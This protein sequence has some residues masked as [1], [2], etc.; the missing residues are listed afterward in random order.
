MTTILRAALAAAMVLAPLPAL[1][2]QQPSP[3]SAGGA[4]QGTPPAFPATP[5][6]E[7]GKAL[8]EALN[9]D[10]ETA[11]R[12]F[13]DTR[14]AERLDVGW[15]RD[16]YAALLA[17]LRQQSGGVEVTRVREMGSGLGVFVRS[18]T[19]GHRL[20]I[21]VGMRGT[22]EVEL[23]GMHPTHPPV[24]AE[25]PAEK[26]DDE[27][28]AAAVGRHLEAVAAADRFSGV[29]V[30]A[31][32]DR[33][34]LRRAYGMADRERGVPMTPE[35]RAATAS[36]G[37][38]A[39]GVAVA[40][41]VEAGKLRFT[42]TLGSLLP[43]HP[44]PDARR[45]TIHQLLTHTAGIAD[46]FASPRFVRGA[47]Y[48]TWRDYLP[49][50]ASE[51]LTM[52]PGERFGYS[53]GNF[54]V[55]AAVVEKASGMPFER[56]VREQVYDRAGMAMR[57]DGP[58]ARGYSHAP[59]WDPMGIEPRRANGWLV[60]EGARSTPVG[61]GFGHATADDLFRFARAL[62]TNR[63]LSPA[64]TET[65]VE[66]KVDVFPGQL[67]YGYGIYEHSWEGARVLG[68]SGGG[69]SSGIGAHVEV[70]WDADWTLVV[71]GNVD[72]EEDV[73]PLVFDLLDFLVKQTKA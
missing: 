51:P 10:D 16:R 58:S 2:Q 21:E 67:R 53:N 11:V 32:G 27:G 18:R 19:G 69:S 7:A 3:N 25:W 40:R 65:V 50:F 55:L 6:G 44:N 57:E 20:G 63:L 39:T 45:V 22:G 1:A 23:L 66:G 47:D 62:K 26:L 33:V 8:V 36:V 28:V 71:L 60:G 9:A 17:K 38:M 34:L 72:L 43:D 4:G 49:L 41:L 56:Y 31:H 13:V 68:H 37:K 73:R 46:P 30:L 61:F 59:E 12:R 15:T 64:M 5:A 42:D 29:V 24:R 14:V 35:T 52:T 54:A 48:P 70:L